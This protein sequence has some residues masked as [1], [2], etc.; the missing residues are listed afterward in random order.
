MEE[1]AQPKKRVPN[2]NLKRERQLRGW[3]HKNVA[4]KIS[5]PDYRLVGRWERGEVFPGPNYR[6]KLCEIFGKDAEALGLL[7]DESLDTHF[8]PPSLHVNPF[9][10]SIQLPS[11]QEFF[12]RARERYILLDRSY[13]SGSTSL[14]GPRRIGKTWLIEYICL[15]A[16]AELG[17]RFRVGYLDAAAAS[18]STVEGFVSKAAQVLDLDFITRNVPQGIL[19]LEEAVESLR[20]KRQPCILCIDEFEALIKHP[21][22]DLEFFMRLR[23][24]A[25]SGLILITASKLP[26]IEAVKDNR[27]TSPFFNIFEQL[28]IG[29]FVQEEAEEFVQ[30]KSATAHFTE[31]EQEALLRYGQINEGQWPPIRLQLTGT[32]LW[33]EK[34]VEAKNNSSSSHSYDSQYWQDFRVR[35]EEKYRAV[36]Q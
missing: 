8:S 6:T 21:E 34:M 13:N 3:S 10:F 24:L 29:P 33:N 32:M 1:K 26:L 28:T 5:C 36:V 25:Q 23:S 30:E 2:K 4:E 31:R 18:C 27:Q 11:T 14:V 22:F 20:A 16:Q 17:S 9:F 19:A 35:L 7:I 15:S 12:G